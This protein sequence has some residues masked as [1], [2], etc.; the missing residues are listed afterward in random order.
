M[1]LK[2]APETMPADRVR[3]LAHPKGPSY[4]GLALPYKRKQ[5]EKKQA[6]AAFRNEKITEESTDRQLAAAVTADA[7]ALAGKGVAEVRDSTRRAS[8]KLN[9]KQIISE[10]KFHESLQTLE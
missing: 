4:A 9:A 8:A 6:P 3:H 2:L 7:R 5:R 10:A 1:F